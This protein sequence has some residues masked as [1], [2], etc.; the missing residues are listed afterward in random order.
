[1]RIVPPPSPP[2]ANDNEPPVVDLSRERQRRKAQAAEAAAREQEARRRSWAAAHESQ[3]HLLQFVLATGRFPFTYLID[4]LRLGMVTESAERLPCEARRMGKP[5]HDWLQAE[6][7]DLGEDPEGDLLDELVAKLQERG[8]PMTGQCEQ[9]V[10]LRQREVPPP[11]TVR[12]PLWDYE[13]AQQTPCAY[14]LQ[15]RE[16]VRY[17]DKYRIREPIATDPA[18]PVLRAGL[19]P[20]VVL[21]HELLSSL[22]PGVFALERKWDAEDA[23]DES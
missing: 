8:V 20:C 14:A 13:P 17:E 9:L 4:M 5:Y 21:G 2:E 1:M 10:Q 18:D 11:N 3:R 23:E 7:R 15:H 12:C 19:R 16:K 22:M 6:W